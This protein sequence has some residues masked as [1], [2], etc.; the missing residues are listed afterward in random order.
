MFELYSYENK[1]RK[2]KYNKIY[3]I[4]LNNLIKWINK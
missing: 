4:S 2:D 1:I 3:K